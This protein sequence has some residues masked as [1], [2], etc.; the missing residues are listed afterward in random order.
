MQKRGEKVKSKIV[1]YS[2][3]GVAAIVGIVCFMVITAFVHS[4]KT[5]ALG[6]IVGGH[7]EASFEMPS[8]HGGFCSFVVADRNQGQ[9]LI[10]EVELYLE[11]GKIASYS[12][13]A[14]EGQAEMIL[15]G[16]PTPERGLRLV[17]TEKAIPA[18]D[19]EG[20]IHLDQYRGKTFRLN[21]TLLRP[22]ETPMTVVLRWSE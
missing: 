6:D 18:I 5:K 22:N 8:S 10:G 14:N 7:M 17:P 21:I 12:F 19:N 15:T 13:K 11:K 9:F 1:W 4:V 2:L 16:K 20:R 3:A